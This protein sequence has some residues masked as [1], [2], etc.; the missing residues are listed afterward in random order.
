LA[1]IDGIGRP[2]EIQQSILGALGNIGA[3]KKD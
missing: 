3:T 2:E 1:Q